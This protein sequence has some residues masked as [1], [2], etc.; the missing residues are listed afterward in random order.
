[1]PVVLLRGLGSYSRASVAILFLIFVSSATD[2]NFAQGPS[3]AAL[4]SARSLN[5]FGLELAWWNYGNMNPS[6]D[7][8]AF[9]T[10]DEEVSYVQ[11]ES[12]MVTAFDNANGRQLWSRK[13]GRSQGASFPLVS[14]QDYAIVSSGTTLYAIKRFS[15]EMGWEVPLPRIPSSSP[16]VDSTQ[17]YIG[18]LDGTVVALDLAKLKRYHEEN[19][20]PRWGHMAINWQYRTGS[21]ITTPP[22][23]SGTVLD[24][25]ARDGSLY[26]LSA[27]ESKI[28]FQFETD[29][30]ISAP[31]AYSDGYLFLASEDYNV[32]CINANNGTIRWEYISGAPIR[33][34][35]HVI[36]QDVF[37]LPHDGG[38][39]CLSAS[40]GQEKWW[41]SRATDFIAATHSLV[42]ASDDSGNILILSRKDGALIGTMPMRD[43]QIRV[44]NDRTDR[45]F[46]GN[47]KGLVLCIHEQHRSFPLYHKQAEQRPVL[48]ELAPED[49]SGNGGEKSGTEAAP[50][51]A[52]DGNN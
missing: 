2:S 47:P 20:L 36:G 44:A 30:P 35:P 26:G 14:N 9:L 18:S 39:F 48:P 32:Y 52:S 3:R 8:V 28:R 49:S 43:Y 7:R 11:S 40:E 51:K 31:V 37:L 17:V 34:A 38:M 1:M 46:L 24:V 29:A 50:E 21:E 22:I 5:R 42:Y 10:A 4:P 45:I 25:A 27:G 12:G 15:G 19:L 41:T 23:T 6:L 13:I 33:K 16:S